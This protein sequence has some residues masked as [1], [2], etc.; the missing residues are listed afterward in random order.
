MGPLTFF[1]TFAVFFLGITPLN[2]SA[3]EVLK[4]LPFV[5]LVLAALLGRRLWGRRRNR[6]GDSTSK[7]GSLILGGTLAVV[8][9]VVPCELRQGEAF[10]GVG[11]DSVTL[12]YVGREAADVL[13]EHARFARHVGADI[14]GATG[15]AGWSESPGGACTHWKAPP[16]HSAPPFRSL[17][18]PSPMS[19]EAGGQRSLG[20]ALFGS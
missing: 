19:E 16:C 7:H 14:P 10:V 15:G 17:P 11:G 4:A 20:V 2:K 6:S 9:L 8:L 3:A 12:L 5:V 13:H 18:E 1:A